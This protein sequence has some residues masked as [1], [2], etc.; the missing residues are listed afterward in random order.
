VIV[1]AGGVGAFLMMGGDDKKPAV[2]PSQQQ[3]AVPAAAPKQEPAKATEA[4][5]PAE[6]AAKKESSTAEP[7]TAQ[8]QPESA[9]HKPADKPAAQPAAKEPAKKEPKKPL[10]PKPFDAKTELQDLAFP[11]DVSEAEKKELNE[12]ATTAIEDSSMHGQKALKK[13]EASGRKA[14][15]AILNKL[16]T[17]DYLNPDQM[18]MA[19]SM[20][21]AI[22]RILLGNN[23]DFQ[24]DPT[25]DT[26]T[27]EEAWHNAAQLKPLWRF[28]EQQVGNGEL[29]PWDKWVALRKEN[30]AKKKAAEE[31]KLPDLDK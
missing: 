7:A 17:L 12:L 19:F 23:V 6:A 25:K 30:L 8:K 10:P 4:P 20:H 21:Q 24:R 1:I 26:I 3:A 14:M 27:Q 5:K 29:E 28:W 9:G 22:E 13:L 11:S 15:P 18:D 2:D 16:R 31:D